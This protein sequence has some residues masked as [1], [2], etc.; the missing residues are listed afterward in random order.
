MFRGILI[1]AS[2]VVL[3]S[4][5]P[6]A[7]AQAAAGAAVGIRSADSR[8]HSTREGRVAARVPAAFLYQAE[9]DPILRGEDGLLAGLFVLGAVAI[10]PI[11]RHF[12]ERLQNPRT[13]ENRFLRVPAETFNV[14][15]MPGSLIIGGSIY[16]YGAI[17]GDREAAALGLHG[18][19]AVVLGTLVAG[20]IKG[21][22]GRARPHVDVTNPRDFALGRGFG[23]RRYT[24][25]P[26]GHAVAGFAAAT[27]VSRETARWWPGTEWVIAPVMYGGA[28]LVGVSRMYTN[29]HWASDVVIGA[30]IGTL[31]GV[32][33]DRY[34]TSRPDN[35]IDRL[36][37]PGEGPAAAQP[38][39]LVWSIPMPR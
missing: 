2:V 6:P 39:L 7:G 16:A 19:E 11:D 30:A 36:F 23:D 34:H 4:G 22:A 20:T 10:A 29:F 28:T 31:A 1:L 35:W 26:S 24:S 15:A 5:A 18:T 37:L 14:V 38:V 25:F 27:V 17:A 8:L 9:R 32:I 3:A 21:L 33:I 12:A 13:Q